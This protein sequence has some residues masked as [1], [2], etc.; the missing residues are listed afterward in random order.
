MTPHTPETRIG[1]LERD[2]ARM[3]QRVH[4]LSQE[5]GQL[6]R[7]P[8]GQVRLEEGLKNLQDDLRE[9]N[10][11]ISHVRQSIKDREARQEIERREQLADS[12][13]WRRALILGSFTVLAAIIAAAAT[14]IA[15]A[16]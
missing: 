5:V 12:R 7:L 6:G 13:N 9:A 8:V 15:S 16:P 11:L 4:D 1:E 10:V 2:M 14:I 3:Q